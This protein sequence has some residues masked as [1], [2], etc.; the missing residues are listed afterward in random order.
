[1]LVKTTQLEVLRG[2][3]TKIADLC[4]QIEV[5][6]DN[7]LA[8]ATQNLSKA[9]DVVKQ[10][11]NTR[12]VLKQPS[13]DEGKKIDSIAKEIS[14]P[15]EDA[16]S[17]GKSKILVYQQQ[18]RQK[19]EKEKQRVDAIKNNI[20]RYSLDAI[21][22][23]NMATTDT[24]LVA[25]YDK[26]VKTFPSKETWQEFDAEAQVMR[27]QLKDYASQR[28]IVINKPAEADETVQSVIEE[29]IAETVAEVTETAV[30]EPTRPKGLTETWKFAVVNEAEIPREMLI[31]DEKKVKE[32]LKLNKENLQNNQIVGGIKFYIEESIRLR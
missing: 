22:E 15:I 32:W 13:I 28:R 17:V 3:A 23:M 14:S 16:V 20:Q 31:L 6:D 29:K 19:Q 8:I 24:E 5:T 4:K 7:S 21:H 18:E 25:A 10:I 27:G 26:F 1:M 9:N 12:K 11:E 2:E 30:I